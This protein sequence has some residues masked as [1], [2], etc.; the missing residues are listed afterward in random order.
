[1]T[2]YPNLLP[3]TITT[4]SSIPIKLRGFGS[5]LQY[6]KW[7]SWQDSALLSHV[8]IMPQVRQD[9]ISPSVLGSALGD[10]QALMD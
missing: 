8:S 5:G 10:K 6:I 7:K 4:S 2:P 9:V 3:C 1:M